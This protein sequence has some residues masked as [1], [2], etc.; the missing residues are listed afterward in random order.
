MEFPRH[1]AEAV[2]ERA[3]EDTDGNPTAPVR[4]DAAGHA[5]IEKHRYFFHDYIDS[6]F[7]H[8]KKIE[9]K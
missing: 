8:E 7:S 4:L 2:V 5:H 1:H 3:D 6:I 9:I